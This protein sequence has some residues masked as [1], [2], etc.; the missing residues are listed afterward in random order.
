M[1]RYPIITL[2]ICLFMEVGLTNAKS[3]EF[4]GKPIKQIQIARVDQMPDLPESYQMID[5]KAKA[6]KFDAYVFDWHNKGKMGP[7]IWKDDAR[8]NINQTT[9]G[10]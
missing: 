3:N 5:W 10:L 8:R 7:L 4:F 6:K 9:F 2:S 1:K